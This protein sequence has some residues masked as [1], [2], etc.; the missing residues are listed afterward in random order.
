MKA[1]IIFLCVLSV[2][3]FGLGCYGVY[4]IID[5]GNTQKMIAATDAKLL[6]QEEQNANKKSGN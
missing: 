4:V 2:A 3:F 6:K 1:L 5:V